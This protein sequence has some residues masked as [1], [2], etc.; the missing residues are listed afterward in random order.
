MIKKIWF[1]R[2]YFGIR[3]L[4][5]W[6]SSSGVSGKC[7][8]A[9]N[10]SLFELNAALIQNITLC[11]HTCKRTQFTSQNEHWK[12]EK[13]NSKFT[14]VDTIC[15]LHIVQTICTTHTW[16]LQSQHTLISTKSTPLHWFE[17]KTAELHIATTSGWKSDIF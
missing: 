4:Q 17:P 7:V 11:V 2:Q 8:F 14:F 6:Y 12:Y 10:Q 1:L 9:L 3:W 16:R 13:N 5:N 15:H